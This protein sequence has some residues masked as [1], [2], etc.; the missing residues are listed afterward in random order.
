MLSVTQGDWRGLFDF[1]FQFLTGQIRIAGSAEPDT[2]ETGNQLLFATV[3]FEAKTTDNIDLSASII[4]LFDN[5]DNGSQE[6][7]GLTIGFGASRAVV[8][9]A[10]FIFCFFP[11]IQFC[12]ISP[13]EIV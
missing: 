7:I 2:S 5:Y 13:K 3:E 11:Y 1:T 10:V 12:I 4:K 9:G 6:P 8:A